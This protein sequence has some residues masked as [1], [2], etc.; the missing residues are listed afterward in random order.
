MSIGVFDEKD[1]RPTR[2]DI[3]R[4]LGAKR[5]L[6]EQLMVCMNA[7][8][9]MKGEWTYGGKNFGWNIWYRKSGET[10]L[11]L[12][13]QKGY[14]VAQ[15]VLGKEHVEKASALTPGANVKD[16]FSRAPQ[17][18]DGRWLYIP[19]RTKRDVVD[20]Q[21]LVQLKRKPNMK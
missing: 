7:V 18:H 19:V 3:E 4:A 10:L 17:F 2:K 15:V 21:A 8:Y 13:P 5:A 14:L 6:F 11:N 1:H 12:F 20:V 9:Q 16:V